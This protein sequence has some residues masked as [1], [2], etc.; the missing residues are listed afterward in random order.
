M[1]ISIWTLIIV[2]LVVFLLG[3][4]YGRSR[5]NQALLTHIDLFY[6]HLDEN[7]EKMIEAVQDASEATNNRIF[8]VDMRIHE[9]MRRLPPEKEEYSP[10]PLDKK[11]VA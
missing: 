3:L 1:T 5:K 8:D 10:Y 4:K 9:V 11:T 7:Q 6:K 2:G